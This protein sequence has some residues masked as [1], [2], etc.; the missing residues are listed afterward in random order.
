[1]IW[2]ENACLVRT[3]RQASRRSWLMAQ[4]GQIRAVFISCR[5]AA[6]T[7]LLSLTVAGTNSHRG[8]RRRAKKAPCR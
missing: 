3:M 6:Q 7:D 5:N 4:T 2:Q 8:T 1:M